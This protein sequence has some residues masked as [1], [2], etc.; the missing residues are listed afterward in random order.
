VLADDRVPGADRRADISR[1]LVQAGNQTL[2]PAQ[3]SEYAQ[4]PS[5]CQVTY[6]FERL[7]GLQLMRRLEHDLKTA[8]RHCHSD[9]VTI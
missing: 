7:L 4:Q 2:Q 1:A 3:A 6:R 5:H 9:K 8:A